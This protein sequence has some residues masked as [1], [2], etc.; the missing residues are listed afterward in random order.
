MI[1]FRNRICNTKITQL[2]ALLCLFIINWEDAIGQTNDPFPV[3]TTKYELQSV[4][5]KTTTQAELKLHI[6]SPQSK[7]DEPTPAIL[8]FFGGGWS[9]GNH[10]HFAPHSKYLASR[11]MVAITAD[12]RVKNQHGTTPI[13]AI[14]DARD[15][16]RYLAKHGTEMGIDTSQIAVGG[17]SAGGHLALCTALINHFDTEDK[18]LY[19]PKALVLYNPV[20]NTTSEGYGAKAM[21]PDSLRAS[22][23]HHLKPSMPPTVI[24]H[25]EQDTTVPI[26]NINELETK[27]DSL[28]VAS[29]VYIYPNQKHGFFNL[30]RQP[31]HRYFLETLY[32]TDQFLAEHKFLV[33]KPTFNRIK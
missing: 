13:E 8:F 30:G 25:G 17:G 15:A 20:V 5:Y 21:G 2:F 18:S 6:Y 16:L 29:T 32:R 4:V 9:S 26:A 24:F 11:G 31:A 28:G 22:P 33:G 12:Y 10:L 7:G 23:V 3:D 19:Q 14:Q 1:M 27:M